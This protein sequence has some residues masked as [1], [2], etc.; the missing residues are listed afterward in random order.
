M[1]IT[2]PFRLHRQAVA[3]QAPAPDDI[4]LPDVDPDP[5][6]AP[7]PDATP[8]PDAAPAPD[9]EPVA[10]ERRGSV[11]VGAISLGT[12]SAY[13]FLWMLVLIV[14]E[15]LVFW[16]GYAAL[17]HL[18][19]LESLSAAAATVLGERVPDSG[20]LPALELAALLP[21]AVVAGAVLAVLWL[22]MSLALVVVHNCICALTGGP[23]VRVRSTQWSAPGP[24]ARRARP[25]PGS[26][27]A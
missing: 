3:Q 23:R 10:A 4:R 8:A 12:A 15:V 13:L 17:A 9:A 20:V 21:W 22:V 1:T 27:P 7:R 24:G 19:V 11:R 2:S 14:V 16:A 6:A 25:T 26:R 18:G 5:G